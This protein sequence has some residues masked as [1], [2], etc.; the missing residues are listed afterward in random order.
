M[1]VIHLSTDILCLLT[2][3]VY[4]CLTVFYPSVLLSIMGTHTH[5]N[6]YMNTHLHEHTLA[7]L[8]SQVPQKGTIKNKAPRD[9]GKSEREKAREYQSKIAASKLPDDLMPY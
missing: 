5:T 6:A 2:N 4:V 7:H 1:Y 9:K 3:G 8:S